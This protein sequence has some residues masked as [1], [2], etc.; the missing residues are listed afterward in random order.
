MPK[1]T[2]ERQKQ[3]V[4]FIRAV[5]GWP[6]WP[7]L[8]VKQYQK[9]VGDFPLCGTLVDRGAPGISVKI[10]PVVIYDYFIYSSEP[11]DETKVIARYDTI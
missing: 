1:L 8:P 2:P 4:F 11:L 10:E 9:Q 7:L 3:E 6:R 5:A